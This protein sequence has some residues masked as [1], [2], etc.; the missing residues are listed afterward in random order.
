VNQSPRIGIVANEVSGDQ[1][2]AALIQALKAKRPALQFEGMTGPQME[3]EGCRSLA[4]MDPVMG[5]VEVLKHLPGL[6][7]VRRRLYSHFSDDPPA[8]FIGVDA[9]DFNLSLEAR[10]KAAGVKTAHFVSPT[11]W[12]WRQ[13]R[14]KKLRHAVDLMLCIFSFEPDFLRN[15]QVPA[16]YVGHPLADEIPMQPLDARVQRSQLGMDPARPAIAM[17]PGS[18]MSEVSRLADDFIN[19]AQ[20]C[21]RRRPELQFV[22]PLVNG[23]IRQ[24][25][26]QRIEAL[27]PDLPITLLDKQPRQAIQ[28]AEVVLTASGTATL[29]VLLLKRPMVVA[30]R[31]SLLTYWMIKYF[32]LLKIP[33]VSIANLLAD[34]AM[35]PEYLQHECRPEKLGSALLAFL[36]SPK[37]RAVIATAYRKIHETLRC[38]AAERA[39]DAVL[40]LIDEESANAP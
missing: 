15:Y 3:A 30:Y 19:T 31:L 25:F 8:L 23:R 20:W 32:N 37:R 17:L 5:L 2:A 4:S 34:E 36:D 11:V 26:E 40:E 33:H 29:E 7:S 39:A 9:P 12:A 18:R 1:L 35:A 16:V 28:A 38:N 22:T 21:L 27:A 13:G 24:A 10:L 14:A 6:L